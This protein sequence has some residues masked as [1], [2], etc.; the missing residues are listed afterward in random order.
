MLTRTRLV[1]LFPTCQQS[2]ISRSENALRDVCR[3]SRVARVLYVLIA[4]AGCAIPGADEGILEEGELGTS[5]GTERCDGANSK[6]RSAMRDIRKLDL[7]DL[8]GN[9]L[10]YGSDAIND[11]L[12]LG[13]FEQTQITPPSLF[14]LPSVAGEDLQIQDITVQNAER[15]QWGLA[16]RF[17]ERELATELA[18]ARVNYLKT[19]A[20]TFYAESGFRIRAGYEHGWHLPGLGFSGVNLRVG[21]GDGELSGRTI[22]A[23]RSEFQGIAN[24]LFKSVKAGRGFVLPASLSD[25]AS[26]APGESFALHGGGSIGVNLGVGMPL[27][28][29]TPANTIGY[30]LVVTAGLKVMLEGSVDVQLAR[31]DGDLAVV[32]VGT[33]GARVKSASLGLEDAW[34]VSGLCGPSFLGVPCTASIAGQKVDLKGRI[35]AALRDQLDSKLNLVSARLD[36]TSRS[37][38]ITLARVRF[39]VSRRTPEVEAALGQAL[40]GDVRL[41]QALAAQDRENVRA[42]EPAVHGVTLDFDLLRSGETQTSYAGIELFGMKFFANEARQSGEIFVKGDDFTRTLSFDSLRRQTGFFLSKHGFQRVSISGITK[43][44]DT[45]TAEAGLFIEVSQDARGMRRDRLV[46]QLNGVIRGLGGARVLSALDAEGNTIE[47]YVQRRCNPSPA[48]DPCRLSV[49]QESAVLEARGRALAALGDA[50]TSLPPGH[51]ELLRAATE[52]RLAAQSAREPDAMLVG[53]PMSVL[54]GVRMDDTA[55]TTLFTRSSASMRASIEASLEA[56]LGDRQRADFE[57]HRTREIQDQSQNISAMLAAFET[58]RARYVAALDLEAQ[59]IETLGPNG[60]ST[61]FVNISQ[62]SPRAELI[63]EERARAA[64]L[65]YDSM[66]NAAK[67]VGNGTTAEAVATFA[68]LN[69][70]DPLHI[71]A[72]L[73]VKVNL[74]DNSLA[75]Y[76]AAGYTPLH[77]VGRGDRMISMSGGVFS[78]DSLLQVDDL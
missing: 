72:T 40:R 20:A 35:E 50:A 38:R 63:A 42:G 32:D 39:D 68:L 10:G 6:V 60:V 52:L 58:A 45:T 64:R 71:E 70:T 18:T 7:S 11:L 37:S 62:T 56:Q 25:V 57:A 29:G 48:F 30:N 59:A 19:G 66:L 46:D 31:L 51:Q 34:G 55:L 23:H 22:T 47:Q 9:G 78:L 44:A 14:G 69:A 33:E 75:Q 16:A 1:S 17:G 12:S 15:L 67:R 26:L 28:V 2:G 61:L 5:C 27:L 49:M 3:R 13:G 41:A 53:P 54:I 73:D 77:Q 65:A 24:S 8:V 36:R 21:F 4:L 43:T 76:R 74:D